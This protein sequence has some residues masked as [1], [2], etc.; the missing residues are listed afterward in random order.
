M[1]RIPRVSIFYARPRPC[2]IPQPRSTSN[3]MVRL[4]GQYALGNQ[5]ENTFRHA[6]ILFY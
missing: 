2:P 5:R 3:G 6:F 1:V 4:A